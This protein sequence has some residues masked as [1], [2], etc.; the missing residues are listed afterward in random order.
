MKTA[1]P[2]PVL[3]ALLD[4]ADARGADLGDLEARRESLE[5]VYLQLTAGA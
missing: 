3:R 1:T 4:W 5:D 2:Q